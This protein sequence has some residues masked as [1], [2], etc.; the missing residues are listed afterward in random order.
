MNKGLTI[1]GGIILVL[2]LL[3]VVV[4]GAITSSGAQSL[5]DLEELEDAWNYE[6][7][8][9]GTITYA[10]S[11]GQGELGF[12]FYLDTPMKDLDEN[13]EGDACEAF[14]DEGNN[15][16]MS[17]DDSSAGEEFFVRECSMPEPGED[18]NVD[19]GMTRIGSACSVLTGGPSCS[20]G[21][22]TFNATS[23][24]HV[25]Y[26]DPVLEVLMGSL[27]GLIGGGLATGAAA[28]CGLPLGLILLIAGLV[29]SGGP[30]PQPAQAYGQATV[31]PS[32][33]G[34]MAMPNQAQ[35]M[36]PVQ[37]GMAQVQPPLSTA[38]PVPVE[39]EA[40]L[41]G[42]VQETTPWDQPSESP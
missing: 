25:M 40:P 17:R 30:A 39:A 16:S 32:T 11:D 36:A 4:G 7:A 1:T 22:Y 18:N 21:D 6:N 34:S 20:D 37:A 41:A 42:D 35:S 27:G 19:Q 8:T 15:V 26:V 24:V 23:G 5:E 10:D 31:M 9:S 38:E 28:C 14:F 12:W 3:G 13:G 33:L 29:S 2:S